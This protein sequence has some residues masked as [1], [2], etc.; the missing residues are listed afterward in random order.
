MEVS[1]APEHQNWQRELI[2]DLVEAEEMLKEWI[3]IGMVLD[4]IYY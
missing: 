4:E 3:I 2:E 1:K